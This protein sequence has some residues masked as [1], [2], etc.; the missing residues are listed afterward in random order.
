[1]TDAP[2]MESRLLCPACQVPMRAVELPGFQA[3]ECRLCDGLWLDDQEPERLVCLASRP[4][5]LLEP[6]AFDD[7]QSVVPEGQRTCPRCSRCLALHEHAGVTLEV[8]P[9]CRGL[10]LDRWELRRLL[11]D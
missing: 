8:C 5:H 1:V 11:A 9:E 2:E 4:E 7:S 3:D 10:W 6:L